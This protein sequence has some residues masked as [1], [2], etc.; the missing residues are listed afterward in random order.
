MANLC[1]WKKD[2]IDKKFDELVKIV[3]NP[4]FVCTKCGRVAN[5]KKWL[6]KP[7]SIGD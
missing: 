5:S 3:R 2:R 7:R 6:C 4:K 1:K